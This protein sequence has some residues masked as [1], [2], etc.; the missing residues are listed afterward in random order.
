M[1]AEFDPLVVSSDAK[2]VVFVDLEAG[3]R[4]AVGGWILDRIKENPE[5]QQFEE[6]MVNL[7]GFMP[8]SDIHDV[9]IY[10]SKYAEPSDASL[11]IHGNFDAARLG[12]AL[13]LAPGFQS[14]VHNTHTL[15]AWTDEK[16]GKRVHACIFDQ[17]TI[18]MNSD[19]EHLK[20]AIDVL[21]TPEKALNEKSTLPRP[22]Q[23]GV[24][25]FAVGTEL[26]ASPGVKE[27]EL[28]RGFLERATI[29]VAEKETNSLVTMKVMMH[30][31][32]QAAATRSIFEGLKGF[33]QLAANAA[34]ARSDEKAKLAGELA[35]MATTQ[36]N[37]NDVIV[38]LA[39]KND[40]AT[41]I[42]DRVSELRDKLPN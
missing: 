1:A 30:T 15:L 27:N 37:E 42:L 3:G 10:G 12:D 34:A 40:T 38:T 32:E 16:N 36:V 41:R 28:L 23:P 31:P 11:V 18:V 8:A 29:E 39:L 6:V 20:A 4:T 5:Y 17:R 14:D 26:G 22:A 7:A 9:T 21:D 33:A 13:T 2:F 35:Q 24:W 25:A 19:V